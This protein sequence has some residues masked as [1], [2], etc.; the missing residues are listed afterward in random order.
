[1]K[2][3]AAEGESFQTEGWSQAKVSYALNLL[4]R[5]GEI[6]QEFYLF[7]AG[8]E[9]RGKRSVMASSPFSSLCRKWS[10]VLLVISANFLC[11]NSKYHSGYRRRWGQMQRVEDCYQAAKG[12]TFI[13]YWREYRR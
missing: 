6:L 13:D 12:K 11:D 7:E 1:M 2:H 10:P 5:E 3:L 8:G 4:S 9:K